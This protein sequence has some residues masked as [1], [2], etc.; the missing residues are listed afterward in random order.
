MCSSSDT[1]GRLQ[2]T[3]LHLRFK[4]PVCGNLHPGSQES[5]NNSKTIACHCLNGM[6]YWNAQKTCISIG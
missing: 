6:P 1:G 4:R 2:K 3:R 5:R